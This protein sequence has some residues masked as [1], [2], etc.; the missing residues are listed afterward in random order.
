L[1]EG[2]LIGFPLTYGLPDYYGGSGF[3]GVVASYFF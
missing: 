2:S 1:T 3:M